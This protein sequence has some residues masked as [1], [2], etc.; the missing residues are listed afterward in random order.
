MHLGVLSK[1]S[2]SECTFDDPDIGDALKYKAIQSNGEPL[3]KWI[4]F[5]RMTRTFTFKPPM[6]QSD[7]MTIEIHATDF[8]GL[9]A[10]NVMKVSF[11]QPDDA[12]EAL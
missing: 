12:E 10:T 1:F 3:P 9:T 5:D 7:S 11:F 8:E 6:E 4:R 2:V